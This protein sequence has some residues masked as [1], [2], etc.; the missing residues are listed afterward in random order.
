MSEHFLAPFHSDHYAIFTEQLLAWFDEHG[1]HHLPWKPSEAFD[2]KT[3]L[4]RVWVSEIMLQQTQVATVIPYF[5]NFMAQFPSVEALALAPIDEVLKAWE[6][7]GYYSRARNLHH[8]AITLCEN[9]GG[10]IPDQ[11]NALIELK[12]IGNT[13]AAA[14]L[15][16]GYDLPFVILD[17]NVRRVLARILGCTAPRNQLDKILQPFADT[18]ASKERPADYTQAIMDF[19][20]TLCS[21]KP[22]CERCFFQDHCLGYQHD[23]VAQLPRP[24]PKKVKPTH[25]RHLLIFESSSNDADHR[26]LMKHT[27]QALD[28]PCYFFEE[29]PDK[30]IW[31]GLYSF[32]EL[33]EQD[34]P[35]DWCKENRVTPENHFKIDAFRHQFSHYTLIGNPHIIVLKPAQKRFLNELYPSG[36][37]VKKSELSRY[38]VPKPITDLLQ[39]LKVSVPL[40]QSIR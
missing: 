38:P 36:I 31:G 19:G 4:Y 1:R 5:E 32:P 39:L 16:Q 25:T 27:E 40:Q 12:G 23:E 8:T 34:D 7:L 28:E 22:A 35:I 24:N 2:L 33:L 6:G 20:A 14:I 9:Y 26:E 13:T 11:F 10:L 29:R 21:K 15:S 18:F 30:G 3:N 17:G 37:W